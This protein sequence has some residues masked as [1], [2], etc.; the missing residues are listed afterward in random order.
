LLQE[1]ITMVI[2]YSSLHQNARA[3]R[4]EDGVSPGCRKAKSGDTPGRTE[5]M[6]ERS[7][8]DG[9]DVVGCL[10]EV[11]VPP[12]LQGVLLCL[13]KL[14]GHSSLLLKNVSS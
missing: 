10:S 13:L 8:G 9:G 4:E 5:E 2:F 11:A 3:A 12:W 7:Q 14:P 1:E 6:V